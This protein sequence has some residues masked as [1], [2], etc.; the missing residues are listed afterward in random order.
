[1]NGL[2]I[3]SAALYFR[4]DDSSV[5]PPSWLSGAIEFIQ[6]RNLCINY[7]DISGSD[8]FSDDESYDFETNKENLSIAIDSGLVKSVALYSAFDS[9]VERS[10][11]KVMLSV[12]MDNG[13]MYVGIEDC[14]LPD[15]QLLLC[16]YN[17]GKETLEIKYGI[18]YKSPFASSPDC[19]AAGVCYGSVAEL[20]SWL[21]SKNQ[22][23][24]RL[25]AWRNE[26]DGKR[27][28]LRNLFR[29]AYRINI[30]SSE[31]FHSIERCELM[32]GEF[33]PLGETLW[34]WTLAASEITSAEIRLHECGLLID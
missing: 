8:V 19:Y 21:S 31:H 7:F 5:V 29:G 23:A 2:E 22:I 1:M 24:G 28:Y 6:S 12:E 14:K 11:W 32:P 30:I 18:S 17:I 26:M 4:S 20:E 3:N 34:I 33:I 13:L 10:E 27:R 16:A 9:E 25:T 15:Q